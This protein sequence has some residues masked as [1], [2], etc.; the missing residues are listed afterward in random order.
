M[1][2][3]QGPQGR[4]WADVVEGLHALTTTV[5]VRS[6]YAEGHPAIARADDV[7]F[8]LFQR[9]LARLPELVLALI[10]G[11][12]VVCERPMPDLHERI[13]TLAEAMLRHDVECIVVQKGLT[14]AECTVLGRTLASPRLEPG[15]AREQ[16]RTGLT[17]VAFRYAE[18]RTKGDLGRG[19]HDAQDFVPATHALLADVA[20][21]IAT[22]TLVDRAAVRS[23]AEQIVACCDRRAFSL[24]QRCHVDGV[25][26]DAAHAVNVA[27]MTAAMALDARLPDAGCVDATA[28][29]LLHDVGHL[30]MPAHIR[31]IPEP[32]LDA[33]GKSLFQHHA[34]VGASALL[35]AGCPPLWVAAALEHHRGVDGKGYPALGASQAPHDIVRLIALANYVDR[36]RTLL[37]GVVDLADEALRRAAARE[38]THFGCAALQHYIRALGV[39]PPGTTVQLSDG[40][41]GLVIAANPGDPRR[42]TVRILTG[43][44]ED[45]RIDLK[46]LDA[47]EDRHMLSI[48]RAVL[49]PMLVRPP[50]PEP[51]PPASDC[52]KAVELPSLRPLAGGLSM[53]PAG[54]VSGLYSSAPRVTAQ[55]SAPPEELEKACL[56]TLGSLDGVPRLAVAAADLGK[57]NLDHRA[58]FVLTF[59]DGM[60][61]IETLLDAS[62]LPRLELLRILRDLVVAG[63]VVV[64]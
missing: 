23:L 31:G 38:D 29:A 41:E 54:R 3:S 51:E 7:V 16:A 62:G 58:G 10:D 56:E 26:D 19:A 14:P 33:E 4:E 47:V 24:Q 27:M 20:R 9:L 61:S 6:H 64:K 1:T 44:H 2:Q 57:R 8:G 22:K 34:Y 48:V 52:V 5:T 50:D 36:R 59:V 37:R 17:H 40:R 42:P 25:G 15:R 18:L 35:T 32:L 28:A 21:S 45:E 11:E 55:S 43:T 49:P 53:P 39:F 63:V 46:Q 60:S 30:F 12:F 13:P